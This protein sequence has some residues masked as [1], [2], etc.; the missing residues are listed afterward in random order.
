VPLRG[1]YR[2]ERAIIAVNNAGI[3][4]RKPKTGLKGLHFSG[5][6]CSIYRGR[7]ARVGQHGRPER[8]PPSSFFKRNDL[9]PAG[10]SGGGK[11]LNI[12]LPFLRGLFL[13]V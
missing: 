11:T 9:A 1:R 7:P 10:D 2:P 5:R 3:V 13:F 12:A 6:N 4:I 8:R